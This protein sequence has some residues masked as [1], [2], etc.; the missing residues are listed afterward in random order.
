L[1]QEE[2]DRLRRLVGFDP[3]RDT[4]KYK[5]ARRGWANRNKKVEE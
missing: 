2:V 3:V 1:S 5:S 4:D